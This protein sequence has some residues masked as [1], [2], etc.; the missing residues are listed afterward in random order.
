LASDDHCPL[1]RGCSSD[2]SA[3]RPATIRGGYDFPV[4]WTAIQGEVDRR[5]TPVLSRIDDARDQ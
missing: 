3:V 5:M 1:L 4:W 2:P